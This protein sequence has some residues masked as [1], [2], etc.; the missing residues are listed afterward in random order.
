MKTKQI[1][2]IALLAII[3]LALIACKEDEPKC[4]CAAGTEH[5]FG[6]PCCEGTGCKCQVYYGV[7]PNG[8]KIYKGEGVTD[9]QTLSAVPNAITGYNGIRDGFGSPDGKFKKVVIISNE[10][11]GYSWNE[12]ILGVDYN[13]PSTFFRSRFE[14]IA[15][16]TLDLTTN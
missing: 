16:D 4:K 8:V 6:Q 5:L 14:K 11:D 7:L 15:N 1:G 2:L 10:E 9:E 13:M 12:N 3:T